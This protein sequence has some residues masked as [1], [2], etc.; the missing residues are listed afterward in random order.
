MGLIRATAPDQ[1]TLA[2]APGDVTLEDAW[3]AVLHDQGPR[4][5]MHGGAAA[6]ADAPADDIDLLLGQALLAI[7]QSISAQ[8]RK[9]QLDRIKAAQCGFCVTRR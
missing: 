8:L 1:W 7:N 4:R 3:Q 9:C 2:G 6:T 5:T